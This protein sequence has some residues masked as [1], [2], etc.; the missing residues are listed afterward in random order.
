MSFVSEGLGYVIRGGRAG[1]DR[2]HVLARSLESGTLALLDRVGVPAGARCL[3][4]GCGPGDVT[5]ELARR[6]GSRGVVTGV[7]IDQVK[8]DIARDRARAAGL[9]NTEFVLGRIEQLP[10]L[11]GHDI[12]YSR[13]VIQHLPEPIE[14]LRIMWQQIA[15]G[16]VLVAEDAD[17]TGTFSYPPSPAV[18]FWTERYS[19][20]LR[21]H[22]GD[23][24]SGRKLVSRF[25]AAGTSQPELTVVQRAYLS[26]EAK[27]MP[28][29][30]VE[31]TAAAMIAADVATKE[32]IE[33]ALTELRRLSTDPTVLL[34][35][36]RCF[37]VW[38]R[39]PANA[40][41]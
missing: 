3:D 28:Y 22:G 11:P 12:V 21:I 1:A 19:R 4:V 34:V 14:A 20:V 32:D 25:V 13:N 41:V 15:P 23:P 10:E 38:A 37:Q 29:L 6:A 16:G 33:D 2:L 7:D 36:P 5:L 9:S 27:A 35:M 31:A 39:R 17:F 26:D 8:L 40:P 24:E 18:D 30:T